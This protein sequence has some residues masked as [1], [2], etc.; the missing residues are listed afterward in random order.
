MVALPWWKKLLFSLLTTAL[1]F[2]LMETLFA[3]AGVSGEA[4]PTDPYLGLETGT[5]AFEEQS[6]RD[7]VWMVTHPEKRTVFNEQSF[8]KQKP[9]NTY[10]VFSVG[11]STTFGH[12]YCDPTS[13]S[14]W[15]RELLPAADASR[16]WEVIN[17]GGIS[18]ASYR[19]AALMEDLTRYEPDLFVVYC[20]HNEFLEE[21]AYRDI[22]RWP[23]PLLATRTALSHT[24]TYAVLHRLLRPLR[25]RGA[26]ADKLPGEVDAVLDHT[27]GPES[28]RRDDAL[29]QRIVDHFTFNL[30][31]MIAIARAA[32][33]AVM[34][35]TP[36]SDL[37]DTS[38]FKS[39]HIA[40]LGKEELDQIHQLD[41]EARTLESDGRIGDALLA[42]RKALAIDPRFAERHFRVGKLLFEQKRYDEALAAFQRARDEDVC[43]LRAL[44]EIVAICRRVAG[45]YGAPLV[46][47]ESL[48]ADTCFQQ[49]GHRAVGKEYFLDHVHPTVAMNG[50]L[51]RAIIDRMIGE[52]IVKPGR[53]WNDTA[54]AAVS[55][56]VEGRIDE[57]AKGLAFRNLAKVYYWSGKREE[58]GRQALKAL[59]ILG[60]DRECLFIAGIA[61]REKGEVLES[62]D[63][64]SR[65]VDGMD[66]APDTHLL[67]GSTAA[68]QG[69]FEQARLH[70]KEVLR[71]RPEDNEAREALADLE[72][73]SGSANE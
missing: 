72:N 63:Y 18:Y 46:D 30:Q 73:R 21:R 27:A 5:P 11:G 59:Q 28:Y 62:F 33:A 71:L 17:A 4:V 35:V 70:Y 9:P 10:R 13:F 49:Q 22:A 52:G 36:A 64:L 61:L 57:Q 66:Y 26:G 34:F 51:A 25:G 6:R 60:D 19:V 16:N 58:A 37:K 67:L 2:G 65:A 56:R 50:L 43:P 14:G 8:L 23:K 69:K 31:R 47:F 12:P 29:R 41:Q 39:E 1:F 38:P 55:R 24:R 7:G 3:L 53:D 40:N 20:G 15:L 68:R 44:T 48:V 45:Q 42:Y 32:G 54:S